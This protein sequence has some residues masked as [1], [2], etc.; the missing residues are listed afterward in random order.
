MPSH[1]EGAVLQKCSA[2][3]GLS[4]ED[5]PAGLR[6]RYSKWGSGDEVIILLHDTAEAGL[7]WASVA[8]R[9]A[10]L[11]YC[12]LAPDMRGM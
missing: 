8:C 6:I 5:G 3:L 10:D 1:Q 7:L 2:V 4:S 9:L 11:G 12:V